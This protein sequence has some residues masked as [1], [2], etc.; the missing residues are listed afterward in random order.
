MRAETRTVFVARDGAEFPSETACR[1]HERK[2]CG[3]AL[4]GLSEAQIE[5]ARTRADPELADAI[6]AFGY[7]LRRARQATGQLRRRRGNGAAPNEPTEAEIERSQDR[8]AAVLGDD[9]TL[10]DHA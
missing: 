6:E 4:I 2:T 10:K 5:A 9:P 3:S 8:L 7:E 1:A